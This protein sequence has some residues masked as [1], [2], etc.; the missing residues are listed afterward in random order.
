MINLKSMGV[1]LLLGAVSAMA[2]AAPVQIVTYQPHIGMVVPVEKKVVLVGGC[3]DILHYGHLQFLEKA[4]AKGE[5]L[6]VA[7]EPDA[8]IIQ[9]KKRQPLHTQ[10]QRAYNLS[11]LSNV[12]AVLLLG[13][14]KT[15]E[16]YAQLVQDIKPGIIAITA[17]DPQ[18]EN[19][20]KQAALV[21][22]TVI[23]VTPR[24]G[25]FSSSKIVEKL[26]EY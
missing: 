5:Y 9:T 11:Q 4:K 10:A 17:D 26:S 21:G 15:F 23:V 12:D 19:K 20:Q 22:A 3:F 14:M 18:W 7:L 16:E 25:T 8:R 1:G 13:E 2:V 6:I 24:I